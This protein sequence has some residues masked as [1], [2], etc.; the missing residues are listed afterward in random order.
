M[1]NVSK[2]EGNQKG[3]EVHKNYVSS[4][5][6]LLG[7]LTQF[8]TWSQS[9]IKLIKQCFGSGSVKRL[10]VGINYCTVPEKYTPPQKE[11]KFPRGGP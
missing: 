6:G 5:V 7:S 4:L 3:R 8:S 2:T 11:L 10:A 9:Q 1:L